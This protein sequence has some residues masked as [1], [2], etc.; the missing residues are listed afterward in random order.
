[1]IMSTTTFMKK[2]MI[3]ITAMKGNMTMSTTTA[4][5]KSMIMSI[6]T[7]MTI[8]TTTVIIMRMKSLRAGALKRLHHIRGTK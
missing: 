5:R 6:T 1:M 8:A 7:V 2:G 4:M 3:T